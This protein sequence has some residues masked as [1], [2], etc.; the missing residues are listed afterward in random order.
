M[1]RLKLDQDIQSL[2]VFRANVASFLEHVQ[3]TKRPLVI[4][5][6]GKSAAVLLAVSEYEA[7]L[8]RIEL[9]SDIHAAD[10][11]LDEEKGIEHDKVMQK[12]K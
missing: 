9:L 6:H 1:N 2:S 10:S 12:L 5:Q 11:Q 4:T 7:L 8:E 3:T